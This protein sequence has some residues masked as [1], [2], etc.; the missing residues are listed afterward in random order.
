M[1]CRFC[2]DFTETIRTWSSSCRGAGWCSCSWRPQS[3][4]VSGAWSPSG[5][6]CRG[7]STTRETWRCTESSRWWSPPPGP[8]SLG[9][10]G[11][12]PW[13]PDLADCQLV[14]RRDGH[15]ERTWRHLVLTQIQRSLLSTFCRWWLLSWSRWWSS[16]PTGAARSSWR[17]TWSRGTP[18]YWCWWWCD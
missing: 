17:R 11:S 16:Q 5:R 13:T 1:N 2:I 8:Q 18:R 4:E 14:L 12:W 9:W 10:S 3:R 7:L 15:L 6:H